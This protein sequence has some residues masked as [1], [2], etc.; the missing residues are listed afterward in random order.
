MNRTAAWAAMWFLA[1]IG[2]G[3]M[4]HRLDGMEANVLHWLRDSALIGFGAAGW[5]WWNR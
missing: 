1:S 2:L 4:A 3:A 5:K